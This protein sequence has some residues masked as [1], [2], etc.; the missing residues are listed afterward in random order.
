MMESVLEKE[1]HVVVGGPGKER[2]LLAESLWPLRPAV[3]RWNLD[4]LPLQVQSWLS[5]LCAVGPEQVLP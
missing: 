5:H 2:A 3:P 1:R 4:D